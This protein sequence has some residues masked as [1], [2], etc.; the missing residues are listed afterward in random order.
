MLFI[1]SREFL[2]LKKTGLFFLWGLLL[3]VPAWTQNRNVRF[4][5]IS[6]EQGSFQS[7]IYFIYQD[8]RGFMW[9]STEEGLTRY[10]GYHFK[11][12]KHDADNSN[13]PSSNSIH[14]I[15]QDEE[16][17]LWIGT[18]GGLDYF[19]P[20]TE[21][22]THFVHQPADPY[23]LSDNVITCFLED[24]KGNLWVGTRSGGVNKLIR[25]KEVSG[26]GSHMVRFKRFRHH[27]E[28]TT[29]V[30]NN[31]VTALATDA[32][33]HLWVGTDGGGLN[34]LDPET[35]RFTH[36]ANRFPKTSDQYIYDL[37][38]D[39]NGYIWMGT[40]GRGFY[41]IDPRT[42]QYQSYT[43]FQAP[44]LVDDVQE[45]EESANGELWMG[46][47]QGGLYYY[48]TKNSKWIHYEG[49]NQVGSLSS[50]RISALYRDRS[51]TLW[52]GTLGKGIQTLHFTKPKFSHYFAE[53][54]SEGIQHSIVSSI[55]QAPDR[56][57]WLGVL[58]SGLIKFSMES[59]TYQ[60]FQ[61]NPADPNSLSHNY[62]SVIYGDKAGKL[63][64]GTDKGLDVFDPV[65]NHFRHYRHNP[66]DSGSL[67][68]NRVVSI[69]QD[70]H[71]DYWIGTADRGINYFNPRTE[72]FKRF[73][74]HPSDTNSLSS[75][76][77]VSLYQDRAGFIWIGTW[78]AGLDRFDP[79]SET[80]THFPY[81]RHDPQR[82]SD[83]WVT[84]LYED[85]EGTLWI[86]TYEGGLNRL[87]RKTGKFKCYL[88]KNG[89]PNNTIQAITED[90]QHY[91]WLSTNKGISR[92]DPQTETFQ[93]FDERDGL[94]A[95]EF[96][97]NAAFRN[98]KG[99]MFFGGVNG[100]NVFH[101]DSI[102]NN[103][104]IPPIVL[105]DL[106][107][108]NQSV[109][110]EEN[111]SNE[112]TLI[113]L[114]Q[115]IT[116][117][118]EIVLP[119]S[120]QV[121]SLEFAALSYIFPEKNRYA[122]KME[123]FDDKWVY[124]GNRR[125]A[126]YTNLDPGTYIFRVKGANNDGKWNNAGV[127]LKITITPPIWRTWWAYLIYVVLAAGVFYLV[128]RYFLYQERLKNSLEIKRLESEKLQEL[129][130]LK[131][132][133]FTN[134]SH[135]F[136]T[137][138]TLIMGPLESRLAALKQDS[139]DQRDFRLMHRN[140]K[141]LLELINQLLDLS[142]LEAGSLK[143]ELVR[144]DI[145]AH[146]KGIVFS[147]ASLAES[148][149]VSLQF[150]SAL[151]E[152]PAEFD[153]DKVEKI[154]TNLLSNAFKYTPEHGCVKVAV[155]ILNPNGVRLAESI[156]PVSFATGYSIEISVSD[157][158]KGIPAE[159]LNKI[160]DRFYQVNGSTTREQ[161][162]TGVGL[163]LT[164]ELVQL[165]K[166]QISV[167]SE[168]DKG[169]TFRVQLPLSQQ[170]S[171]TQLYVSSESRYEQVLPKRESLPRESAPKQPLPQTV[172]G[173]HDLP[174]VLIVEDN[175]EVRRYIRE[176]FDNDYRIE[177][178]GHGKE[179]LQKATESAPDLI[180]SDLMM[181]HMDGIELCRHLKTNELTSHIPVILL[182]AK[183]SVESKLDGL[184]TGADDYV[185]K[186]F[187]PQE[188][189]IRVRNL[190]ESRRRMREKFGQARE[191]KIALKEIAIT[192]ADE[193][194]LERAMAVVEK[195]LGDSEFGVEQFESEMALSKLQ[196][197]RKLK[198]LTDQSPS[199]FIRTLR[200]K[201]AAAMIAARSGTISE[202]A[203]EV[204]FNNLSY[205]AKCFREFYGVPP[206][207]Y[208]A[209]SSTIHS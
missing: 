138:L 195:H 165:H 209:S 65:H 22:F 1:N 202:I 51:G 129:D 54:R 150:E 127:S 153:K 203:Y 103:S 151:R 201:R 48:N 188:L 191:V 37:H 161:G 75:D 60:S 19:N 24:A 43:A 36:Y 124:C 139:T 163:A 62:L 33:G 98:P 41:R 186:P 83:R 137:P 32:R 73:E 50:N 40:D 148:H 121:F 44:F 78:N 18:T 142:K 88:E 68:S 109:L 8:R 144:G 31:H 145:L 193:K 125:F 45:I 28:D 95:N 205:F 136:R 164:R 5:H 7:S 190:M 166:G 49:N 63:W 175:D 178:A 120:A 46:T 208:A 179:G 26:K 96:S 9:F 174:V 87:D 204:G 106:Q 140:A 38:T 12:Y 207:E 196:L 90:R 206:S 183:A 2:R 20:L 113:R 192:S 57:V 69:I 135:E 77:T 152:I 133:F 132:R 200:L 184:E 100:F 97:M 14:A 34:R 134:I 30:S 11:T 74:H 156:E 53:N 58:G 3:S 21:Q 143:L 154:L 185:T 85:H 141:R 70:R 72:T 160:F 117:S 4:N 172:G 105:T 115:S 92:F 56:T 23:S 187:N 157:T 29:S 10:D 17:M 159:H 13:T 167:Q 180:I 79:K 108:Q 162:G 198:A 131:T 93:N 61:H 110:L 64:I 168:E 71:G 67:S 99:E 173:Q 52:I 84:T 104:F 91:L 155:H 128:F 102:R 158:G 25:S 146:L 112:N 80:F 16:G 122:Y 66:A 182:T 177:L 47:W 81:L 107:I 119:Y 55:Y 199:E 194:F 147:F 76:K 130:T 176:I 181:P 82:I 35:G 59:E 111:K 86:G 89:L 197:Y 94:Q 123:G 42:D 15:W 114:P 170:V 149:G 39:A 189:R 27:P 116:E 169:T 118:R 6:I 101:P 171:I 126:T